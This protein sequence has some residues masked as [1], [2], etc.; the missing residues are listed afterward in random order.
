[1]NVGRQPAGREVVLSYGLGVDSTALLLRWLADPSAR[2][3]RLEDLTVVTAMTG[4]EHP[5][6]GQLVTQHVLPRLADAGVR[7]VQIARRGQREREGVEILDD[8]TSPAHLYLAGGYALSDEL[9][10]AGTVPQVGGAR[11]CSV[12]FKGWVIDQF[13]AADR[14]GRPFRQAI[15]FDASPWE[16]KRAAR[17]ATFD[18]RGRTGWY[19]LQEWDWDR[20]RCRSYI[21]NATGVAR[22]PKSACVYC[23]FT[24]TNKAGMAAALQRFRD[25]PAVAVAVLAREHHA[26]C[27]NPRQGL[28]AGRRLRDRLA[29]DLL[30]AFELHLAAQPHALYEVRRIAR[31]RRADPRTV[32]NSSRAVRVVAVG[33][34]DDI[35]RRLRHEAAALGAAVDETDVTP[36]AWLRTRPDRQPGT[37]HYLC[38]G[39]AGAVD[40]QDPHFPTWWRRATAADLTPCS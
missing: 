16:R 24:L 11:L 36:R 1:M 37:E 28:I 6:T 21:E 4:D 17:D 2:D 40:K 26:L 19:P 27:L 25:D 18:R 38:A 7:F 33:S 10:A 35:H 34:R 13:L 15:G 32:G 14:A 29:P 3:F 30:A 8:S 22:W 31:P 23:P 39:T 5:A 12:K 9:H 20:R